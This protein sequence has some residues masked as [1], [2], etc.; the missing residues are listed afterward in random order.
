MHTVK[1]GR[2]QGRP[3]GCLKHPDNMLSEAT[4]QGN[5]ALLNDGVTRSISDAD[6]LIQFLESEMRLPI[7]LSGPIPRF[8]PVDPDIESGRIR[9]P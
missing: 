5:L 6:E 9:G 2:E 4:V 3:I 8:G 1:F 7:S